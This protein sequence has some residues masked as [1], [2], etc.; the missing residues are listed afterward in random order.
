MAE[1]KSYVCPN[2][3][4]NTTNAQNCEY[5]GSLLVRFVEKG[6]DLS[7]SNYLNNNEVFPGLIEEL[8]R[9][10][11][12]QEE[13]PD[14]VVVTDLFKETATG[15]KSAVSIISSLLWADGTDSPEFVRSKGKKQLCI[16]NGFDTYTDVSL[17]KEFNDEVNAQ[18]AKFR[19]LD[20]FPLFTAH[21]CT[22][23]DEYG[24]SRYGREYAI[25]FGEDAE[26]A[27]RLVSEI[28]IKVEGWSPADSYDMFTNAGA[29]VYCARDAWDVAHGF[30]EAS[31]SQ[32]TSSFGI[33]SNILQ[34]IGWV[35]AVIFVVLTAFG[36]CE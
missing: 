25:N 23:T 13:N 14:L 1:L 18:L 20:S 4:A 36:G 33:D 7:H 15:D 10:L 26:G 31:D 29:D 8:K 12:L 21:N 28:L 16:T 5:C 2:C 19:Q 34:I 22:Y 27:A 17:A 9:N 24:F 3:G 30:A 11:K 35:V 32:Q 6:I